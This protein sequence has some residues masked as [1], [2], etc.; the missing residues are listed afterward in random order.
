MV[1]VAVAA[2]AAVVV[3]AAGGAVNL[4]AGSSDT[5]RD[6][7]SS[8]NTITGVVIVRSP[9]A[10]A[11]GGMNG[12]IALRSGTT[13]VDAGGEVPIGIRGVKEEQA[14]CSGS[15]RAPAPTMM[16]VAPELVGSGGVTRGAS[17]MPRLNAGTST[18]ASTDDVGGKVDAVAGQ[19]TVGEAVSAA[20]GE[21]TTGAGGAAT[22]LGGDGNTEGATAFGG[23]SATVAGAAG[24]AATLAG[25]AGSGTGAGGAVSAQGG[26]STSG[27]DGGSTVTSGL[28]TAGAAGG[29]S[30]DGGPA[31]N[32]GGAVSAHHQR[33][34]YDW[35]L[36]C[37]R[38]LVRERGRRR[39]RHRERTD[40]TQLR[41]ELK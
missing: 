18:S 34:R 21:G 23:W 2:V 27:A 33:R 26:A 28:R 12:A 29:V 14:V 40:L 25:G 3:G 39:H 36:R 22:L 32:G 30:V 31:W 20:G 15:M 41:C 1:S 10:K 35:R 16:L 17:G 5:C 38:H 37:G 11:T 7:G 4:A 8:T 13:S 6:G 9:D 19:G 24:G